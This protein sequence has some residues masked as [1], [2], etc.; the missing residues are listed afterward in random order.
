MYGCSPP[1]RGWTGLIYGVSYRPQVFPAYAGMDRERRHGAEGGGR[2]PRL[3]GDGP[4]HPGII[5]Q[6]SLCS[7]PTRGWTAWCNSLRGIRG[8]F[9]AYA[10]MDRLVQFTAGHP[11]RV[12]RLRGDGPGIGSAVDAAVR[13]FP[14]YAGMD[15]VP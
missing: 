5:W 9:P 14:A 4:D 10:G 13:V 11:R 6:A 3:R 15:R 8:V 12:P 2:V 1:T 7:P